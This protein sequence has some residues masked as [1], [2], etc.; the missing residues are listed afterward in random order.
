[1][2]P[3][4]I[5]KAMC[6]VHDGSALCPCG[7]RRDRCEEHGKPKDEYSYAI[8]PCGLSREKCDVH[9]FLCA[10]GNH[11]EKCWDCG[12]RCKCRIPRGLCTFH[13]SDDESEYDSEPKPNPYFIYD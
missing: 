11:L 6:A 9:G 13:T 10:C 1:M 3:C 5:H 8:C 7:L 4:G 12:P 2:C